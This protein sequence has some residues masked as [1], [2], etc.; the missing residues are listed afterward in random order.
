MKKITF[1]TLLF[2]I[3]SCEDEKEGIILLLWEMSSASGG[4]YLIVN[5]ILKM[6]AT[7][8]SIIAT[9]YNNQNI[10]DTYSMNE[11][12]INENMDGVFIDVRNITTTYQLALITI[13]ETT[14]HR[15]IIMMRAVF[16]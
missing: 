4:I 12:Q 2:L 13:S 1:F 6:G 3:V 16:I 8:G 9:T 10:L 5:K 15:L 14:F 11:L 7:D